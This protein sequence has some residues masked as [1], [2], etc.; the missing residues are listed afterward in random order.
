MNILV[1]QN[2]KD[3]AFLRKKIPPVELKKE[4]KKS[5]KELIRIMRQVMRRANG[6]GLSA[7]QI[8]V[9]KRIF[10]AEVPDENNR[11]KFY[12][13]LNPEIVKVA[14]EKKLLEEGCL[15]VPGEYGLVE[16]SYRVT[17]EGYTIEGKKIKV[18]AWG[19]LAH[20]FQHE[21]DHLNGKLFIDKAK[22]VR[23]VKSK[24]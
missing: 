13:F 16:R 23:K 2:K 17:L 6:I 1:V 5:L 8:G 19:L 20:V 22:E 15:S 10:V 4:T 14:G 12:A 9:A 18:K 11:M 24:K 3:N 7:N 21:V